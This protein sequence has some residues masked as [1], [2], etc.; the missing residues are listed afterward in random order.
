MEG[1]GVKGKNPRKQP[2]VKDVYGCLDISYL[3]W[4]ALKRGRAL[5][6]NFPTTFERRHRGASGNERFGFIKDK[7]LGLELLNMIFLI[8][9]SCDHDPLILTQFRCKVNSVTHIPYQVEQLLVL[10][11]Q[12][13][14]RK[15][16]CIGQIWMQVREIMDTAEFQLF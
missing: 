7:F 5:V 8:S 2:K 1:G 11:T 12:F 9:L 16:V 13:T 4:E 10:K 6:H 3:R 14:P 15:N